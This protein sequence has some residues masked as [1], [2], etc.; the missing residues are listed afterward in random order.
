MFIYFM[1]A[2]EVVLTP[3]SLSFSYNP[4]GVTILDGVAA[5]AFAIDFGV[6]ML[7][8]FVNE[9]GVVV[10]VP[11]ASARHYLTSWWAIPDLC[12]WFPFELL[13]FSDN[14][15]RF[16]GIAKIM[17]LA[18]VGELA[19][20][21]L[22]A[23]RANIFRFLRLA[24]VILL[25]SHCCSCFWH[26]IAVEWR[27]HEDD[28]ATKTLLQKYVHCWSLVIGCLN[29]SPPSMYTMS[30][31]LAVAGFMLLGNLVQASV[32]GSVAVVISSFDEDEAAYKRKVITT[33]ERCKFLDIPTKLTQRIQ[34][35]YEHMFRQTKSINGDADS[36]IHELSP[37]LV[38]EVKYQLYKDMLKQIPFFSGGTI[39]SCVLEQL[40]LHLRTVV[41]MQDDIVIRKGEYGDWMGFVGCTGSVGVLDPH[42][43]QRTV[44]RILRKGDYFGETALL[45]RTRRTTTAVALM[46]VQIHV[47][48]RKDLDEVKEMYP[49]QEAALEAE[50]R[51]YMKAKAAY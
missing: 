37:A 13:F 50:I 11:A 8:S 30:E 32:F 31:E 36:F 15:S 27:N 35:Y 25:V 21:V 6:N 43:Q 12:S 34:T 23:R 29:A 18:R 41:Y 17:R 1:T 20:R 19:R 40:V 4:R 39:D 3:L 45:Q 22:S 14:Q 7:S 47:L 26:W 44:I 49:E 10:A 38:C 28:W 51:N 33:Y 9:R 2:V 16:L 46:W 5:F 24:G 48:C 42:S